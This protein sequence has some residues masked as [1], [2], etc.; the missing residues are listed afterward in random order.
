MCISM[1]ATSTG[2][3]SDSAG[4][5]LQRDV[6]PI[7]WWWHKLGGPVCRQRLWRAEMVCPAENRVE[8]CEWRGCG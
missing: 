6:F 7:L 3:V 1:V 4:G 2:P 5:L 8:G